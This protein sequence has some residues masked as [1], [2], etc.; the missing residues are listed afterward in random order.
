[1]TII[2]EK[3]RVYMATKMLVEKLLCFYQYYIMNDVNDE[4]NLYLSQKFEVK[5]H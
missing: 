4:M 2:G 1:M 3:I 5:V